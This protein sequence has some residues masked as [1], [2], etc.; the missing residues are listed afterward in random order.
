MN[1]RCGSGACF[2]DELD[3][4]CFLCSVE[5]YCTTQNHKMLLLH[6]VPGTTIYI[7]RYR[8]TNVMHAY[9]R[10]FSVYVEV[11][12]ELCCVLL[13]VGM[14]PCTTDNRVNQVPGSVTLSL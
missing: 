3:G 8:P 6:S 9:K 12:C 1:K 11:C 2:D 7:M 13:V 10:F 5:Y 14:V 4:C